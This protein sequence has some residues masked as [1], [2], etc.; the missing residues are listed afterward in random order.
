MKKRIKAYGLGRT[1]SRSDKGDVLDWH[2]NP[3]TMC[4]HT[5]VGGGYKTMQVLVVEIYEKTKAED[6]K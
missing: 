4:I 5:L 1:R 6:S 3:Y 2:L